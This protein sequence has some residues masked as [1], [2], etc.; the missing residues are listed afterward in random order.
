MLNTDIC[1]AL[2]NEYISRHTVD[3]IMDKL[4][5][6]MLYNAA[7]CGMV[8]TIK[9]GCQLIDHN[10]SKKNDWFNNNCR[11]KRK[12]F[13]IARKNCRL[14]MNEK[15]VHNLKLTAKEYK[16][17]YV[18]LN[19]HIINHLYINFN[20]ADLMIRSHFGR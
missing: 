16:W 18:K 6:V 12:F 4:K 8:K 17:K 3:S 13:N 19:P 9:C 20:R 1:I 10:K 7:K 5:G 11:R 15:N 2:Q 14:N